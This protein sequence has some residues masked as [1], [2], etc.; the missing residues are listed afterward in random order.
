MAK[1]FFVRLAGYHFTPYT[2]H[3]IDTCE[4]ISDQIAARALANL[5][6]VNHTNSD[7][8]RF[9]LVDFSYWDEAGHIMNY[10]TLRQIQGFA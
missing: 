8:V 9:R 5:K 7:L 1:T 6:W 2:P 3:N 10:S 4:L